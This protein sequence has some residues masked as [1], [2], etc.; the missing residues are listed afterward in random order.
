MRILVLTDRFIP[1]IAAPAF[2]TMDHAKVW[3][4]TGHEVTVVTCA[5]NFPRGRTFPGYRNALYREERLEGVR[6]I[7]VWSYMAA[8]EG[9]LRRVVDHA[10]FLC[11]AVLQSPRFPECDVVLAT[12]PPLFVAVAGWMIARI[13]RKPWVFELRDLWPASIAAVGALP[14]EATNALEAMELALY[15]RADRIMA[16]TRSFKT[17]LVARGIDGGKID[18]V[19]NGVDERVFSRERATFD[20]RRALGIDPGVF[21]AGYIGTVGMAHG[22]ETLVEAA[23]L[24]RDDTRIMF[25]IMGEGAER[26][27]LERSAS[28]KRLGNVVFRDFVAHEAVPA[29]LAALDCLIVHLKPHPVFRTV[30]P[31]KIFEAMA[32]GIPLIHAVEGESARI[33]EEAGAGVCIPSGDPAA[34]AA[35]IRRMSRDRARLAEMGRRG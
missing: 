25:L 8:N 11:S 14:G 22:L 17:D 23:D 6:V 35:E 26:K 5:P 9:F 1:E 24:C 19:E 13:T 34:M 21:L 12:S 3:V 29:Y 4:E 32:M 16:L 30:I 28:D 10:S 7:R 31:S 20:A 2:R 27:K 18:V 15:K 33:V